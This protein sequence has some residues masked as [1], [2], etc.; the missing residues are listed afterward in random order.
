MHDRINK[1]SIKNQHNTVKEARKHN[2]LSNWIKFIEYENY[3]LGNLIRKRSEAERER[4]RV[5]YSLPETVCRSS[6]SMIWSCCSFW[7]NSTTFRSDNRMLDLACCANSNCRCSSSN[8]SSMVR[9]SRTHR[10]RLQC[11]SL[12]LF[13]ACESD[14]AFGSLKCSSVLYLQWPLQLW[15]GHTILLKKEIWIKDEMISS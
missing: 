8:S 1:R 15:S 9:S 6:K 12:S 4:T 11:V 7:T 14:W 13:R 5:M 10:R 2:R 3:E